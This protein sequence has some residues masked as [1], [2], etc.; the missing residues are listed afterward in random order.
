MFN[1]YLICAFVGIE[2]IHIFNFYSYILSRAI[3]FRLVEPACTGRLQLPIYC[4]KPA[5]LRMV[6]EVGFEPTYCEPTTT[7]C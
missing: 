7:I 6:P 2:P 1:K 4:D 3:Y 5:L